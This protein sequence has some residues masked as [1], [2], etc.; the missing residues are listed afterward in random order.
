[1]LRSI[2]QAPRIVQRIPAGLVAIAMKLAVHQMSFSGLGT[3]AGG[4][5]TNRLCRYNVDTL[6]SK[7]YACNEILT[8][9]NLRH[10]HLH[11]PGL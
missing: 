5:M 3:R 6:C 8:S 11:L 10:E 9:V 2:S 1:M 4:P 7:I